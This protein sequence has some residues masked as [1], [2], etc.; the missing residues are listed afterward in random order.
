LEGLFFFFFLDEEDEASADLSSGT[1][2]ATTFFSSGR[3]KKCDG[4]TSPVGLGTV[5]GM[6]GGVLF[7]GVFLAKSL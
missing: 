4:V 2:S 6:A 1:L 7:S 3:G 5:T